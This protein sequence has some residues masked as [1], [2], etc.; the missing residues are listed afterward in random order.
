MTPAVARLIEE[1]RVGE[2]LQAS[3]ES[4]NTAEKAATAEPGVADATD[5]ADATEDELERFRRDD[6]E[7]MEDFDQ[8][9]ARAGVTREDMPEVFRALLREVAEMH[10]MHGGHQHKKRKTKHG[11]HK[12]KKRGGR[13]RMQ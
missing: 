9:I 8:R 4:S 12:K 5:A 11:G 7:A 6:P 13:R 10:E 2:A 1:E 3:M